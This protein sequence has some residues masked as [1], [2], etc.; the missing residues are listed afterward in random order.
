MKEGKWSQCQEGHGAYQEPKRSP[1]LS[2]K[3]Q[4][5]IIIHHYHHLLSPSISIIHHHH[6]YLIILSRSSMIIIYHH[7][8]PS[9]SI[10]IIINVSFGQLAKPCSQTIKP[11]FQTLPP[12]AALPPFTFQRWPLSS[13]F[14]LSLSF[15]LKIQGLLFGHCTMS[16]PCSDVSIRDFDFFHSLA[17]LGLVS[18]DWDSCNCDWDRCNFGL[19]DSTTCA[20]WDE[21]TDSGVSGLAVAFL[22]FFLGGTANSSE[23]S[24][25]VN[26]CFWNCC[27]CWLQK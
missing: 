4:S 11:G 18:C 2:L 16:S 13:V 25:D 27:R 19:T 15:L 24:G 17:S 14:L 6:L 7:P 8:S 1:W 5:S 20:P 3:N 23:R 10:I 26:C 21:W 12:L 22:A 9:T